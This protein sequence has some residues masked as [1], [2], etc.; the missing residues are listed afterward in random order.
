[1]R[2]SFSRRP[3]W[4][5]AACACVCLAPVIAS[6]QILDR[7]EVSRT[8]GKA[9]IRIDFA[10]QVQYLNHTPPG[11]GRELNIFIRPI[12]APPPGS[13]ATEES[14][15]SP[16]TDLV[17]TFSVL[18][19]HL[20]NAVAIRFAQETEWTVRPNPDGRSIVITLPVLKGARDIVSEV[21]AMP[22]PPKS[23]TPAPEPRPEPVPAPAPVA[24]APAPPAP[25]AAVTPLPAAP[26]PSVAPLQPAPAPAPEAAA[27]TPTPSAAPAAPAPEAPAAP[28][29]PADAGPTA[30]VLTAA[31]V[32]SLAKGFLDDA[33]KAVADNDLPRAINRLNRTLGLPTN[34]Q[35]EAAQALIGEVREKNGEIAKAKAEYELYLKLYPKGAEAKRIQDRLAALPKAAPRAQS[36][37][38]PL[39][40]GPAEW[41][42]YG[43]LSQYYYTGKSHIEVTTPPPPGLLDFTTYSLSQTDQKS[44]ITNLDV[45]ARKRDG[46]TDTRIVFRDMYN[47]NQL[48]S[49][50]TYNRLYSAYVEQTDKELGYFV[51]AGR[52]SPTG[53]GVMERFDGINAGYNFADRWRLNGV[54][55]Y[56]VEFMS[57]WQKTFYGTS[58]EMQP[59]PDSIGLT[60]YVIRQNLDGLLN[61]QAVGL[62]SRYFDM[63]TTAF[64]M[65]DY[66]TL[67][68]GVNIFML[69]GNYRTDDGMNIFTYI[70]HRKAPAYSLTSTYSL[71]NGM[72]LKDAVTA[73]GIEQMRAD[74]R[75][76]TATSNLLSV[77]FTIPVSQKW[78]LGADYRAASISGTQEVAAYPT[79]DNPVPD[80]IVAQPSSGTSH[81][82][83][84][85]AIGTT[86]FGGN[87]VAV[88]NTNYI[89]NPT[90]NGQALG[91]NFVYQPNDAWRFDINLRYYQQKDNQE[92]KQVRL[93]PSLRFGYRWEQMVSIEAEFGQEDV[94]IDGPARTERDKRTYFYT[95]Y[96]IDLR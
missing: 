32:E 20:G 10:V 17:P 60:G 94:R 86:L 67:Y 85:Q 21:R 37:A 89:K 57:P 76:L 2:T 5:V 70:D 62:E 16:Q 53:S 51:R 1:M 18:Y 65:L 22:A 93:S 56:A 91:G 54:A 59:Q 79:Y 88:I 23:A 6:A 28:V 75:L 81:V 66:D 42:V 84:L 29:E 45:N 77:G 68:K 69:Q 15:A 71:W 52:Q 8:N 72:T 13:E 61:R 46:I 48:H 95:G 12:N 82:V 47:L 34:E 50:R 73:V 33:R 39:V 24:V 9:E 49:D 74:A 58:L 35:T 92:E 11:K 25:V 64:T 31:Q 96:R 26:A 55:G 78:Q 3:E 44:L 87:S 36:R 38:R 41:T 83:G 30:P 14:M 7:I 27:A 40:R 4:A 80:K 90:Y 19:P 43:S 63:H